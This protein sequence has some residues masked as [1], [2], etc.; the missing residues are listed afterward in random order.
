MQ[1][2]EHGD[3]TSLRM[4]IILGAIGTGLSFALEHVSKLAGAVAGVLTC[5]YLILNIHY[6]I[7]HERRRKPSKSRRHDDQL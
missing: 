6:K 5:I 4:P 2:D 7:R 3:Q 1:S